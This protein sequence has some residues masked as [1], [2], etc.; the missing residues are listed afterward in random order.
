MANLASGYIEGSD[1]FVNLET[2]LS[3][4]LTKNNIY[5][6]QI[7]KGAVICESVTK[8][9]TGG[10]YWDILKPFGYKKEDYYF[11]IKVNKGKSVYV[12]FAE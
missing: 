1:E 12:N 7:Q 9:T 6:V 4:S 10:F 3:L 11:W 5:Q 8:P 2:A